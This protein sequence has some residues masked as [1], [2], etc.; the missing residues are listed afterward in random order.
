V[1]EGSVR[2]VRRWMPALVSGTL[3]LLP[4]RWVSA[5]GWLVRTTARRVELLGCVP[6]MWLLSWLQGI[7]LKLWNWFLVFFWVPLATR[8]RVAVVG[9]VGERDLPR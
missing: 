8:F 4:G 6:A 5:L 1:S 3:D 7:G 2:R 9:L